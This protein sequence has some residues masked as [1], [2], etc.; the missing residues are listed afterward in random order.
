M[1]KTALP[2]LALALIGSGA[3]A[4]DPS[5][6]QLMEQL[7]RLEQR[8]RERQ[9]QI[10]ALQQDLRAARQ[11][12]AAI[13]ERVVSETAAVT[14]TPEAARGPQRDPLDRESYRRRALALSGGQ[15]SSGTAFNPA[16]SVII[17]GV[18][19]A[20]NRREIA[21]PEGF[22]GHDDGHGHDQGGHGGIE[23]GFNL[24]ETEITFSASI[25]NYFDALVTL[26]VEGASG[27]EIEEAYLVTNSLPAGAQIKFGRFLSDVGYINKQHT[28]DWDFVDRP[29]VNAVIF[30]DHGLQE[31]GVQFSWVP[32]TDTYTRFGIEILQGESEGIAPYEGNE[33]YTVLTHLP[34]FEID[35]VSGNPITVPS[36][37][38]RI[39]WQADNDLRDKSGPRLFTAFVKVAPDLGFDHAVQFGAS[40]GKS[41][42]WQQVETH[43]TG[44]IETWDGDAWFAGVDAVYKYSSGKS[45]GDGNFVLQGEYFYR[46]IDVDYASRNF[47][48]FRTLTPTAAGGI[49][50][51]FSGTA[52]QDGFYV[53]GLYGVAPR[54]QLGLRSEGVGLR[55]RTLEADRADNAFE[56]AG[57][58]WRHSGVLTFRPTEFS[59]LR[60]QVNYSDFDADEHGDVWSFLLQYNMSLGVH[61]AHSF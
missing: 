59:M 32:A 53:Q 1:N 29:L 46:E 20:Q 61:G 40:A 13:S 48:D 14:P 25:D 6:Q 15:V 60:A 58:S 37:P 33:E 16:M 57:K 35:P 41:R 4:N 45:L 44:R 49:P 34:N 51:V 22:D 39:R 43:S 18:Y 50:D 7:E 56:R 26:A 12:R 31:N 5:L 3:A 21:S 23:R 52:K 8:D 47:S 10:E 30:G 27:I 19:A 54:W 11:D 17:D 2:L 36:A 24:R 42:A 9:Q 55:N 28:H 38:N